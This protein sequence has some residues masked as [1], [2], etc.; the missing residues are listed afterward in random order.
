MRKELV[1]YGL[2]AGMLVGLGL[3]G[4]EAAATRPMS[5]ETLGLGSASTPAAMCG[6]RCAYGGATSQA[7]RVSALP[8]GSTT[9]GRPWA[10]VARHRG[11]D[12][13]STAPGYMNGPTGV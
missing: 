9:A 5:S 1:A 4:A 11:R 13:G 6:F 12:A 7:H 8:V 2:A 10:G 3:S